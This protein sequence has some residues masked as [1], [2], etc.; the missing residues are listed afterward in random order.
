MDRVFEKTRELGQALLESDAYLAMKAAEDRAMQN[1]EAANT[2]AQFLEKRNALHALMQS[3]NPDPV[4]MK[5]V[6]DE[7][8]GLA[9]VFEQ[10][11]IPLGGVTYFEMPGENPETPETATGAASTVQVAF[12][13]LPSFAAAV[14]TAA[15]SAATP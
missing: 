10:I 7:M 9:A 14:M 4:A 1:E 12:T 6:S 8:D 11:K 2:M 5:R 3:E 15:P 13:P